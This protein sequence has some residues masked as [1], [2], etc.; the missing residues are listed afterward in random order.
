MD[1]LTVETREP[2][3]CPEC[4]GLHLECGE[5]IL[6]GMELRALLE[7]KA[8]LSSEGVETLMMVGKAGETLPGGLFEAWGLAENVNRLSENDVEALK[9]YFARISLI[10]SAR[11]DLYEVPDED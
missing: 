10:G 7:A 8:H 3:P 6:G 4:G 11:E 9:V 2:F 5:S 1:E